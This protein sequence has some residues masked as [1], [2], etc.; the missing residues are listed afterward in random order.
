MMRALGLPAPK[1]VCVAFFQSGQLRQFFASR[2]NSSVDLAK[3]SACSVVDWGEVS[4]ERG[5]ITSP[6]RTSMD[7]EQTPYGVCR[8][9]RVG[10]GIHRDFDNGAEFSY[11]THRRIK[12][13]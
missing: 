11:K 6:L 3:R 4:F 9:C 10:G 5:A 1:T 8:M 13:E 12:S 2:A 7:G